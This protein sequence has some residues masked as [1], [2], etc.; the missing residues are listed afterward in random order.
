MGFFFF[1]WWEFQYSPQGVVQ[2]AIALSEE[3]EEHIQAATAW[4]L[5]Q[6]GRHTPEHAKAIAQANVLPR[7]LELYLSSEGAEDLQTKVLFDRHKMAI[8]GWGG[9]LDAWLKAP[10][11]WH[12]N[13]SWFVVCCHPYTTTLAVCFGCLVMDYKVCNKSVLVHQ[14]CRQRNLWRTFWVAVFTSPP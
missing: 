1:G 11:V 3:T 7:L 13:H 6:I 12:S 10:Q 2:L 5:G 9:Y 8:G 14:S 4:A